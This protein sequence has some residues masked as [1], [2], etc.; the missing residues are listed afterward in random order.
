MALLPAIGLGVAIVVLRLLAP[1]IW[2]AVEEFA[3]S[4]FSTG[5]D[6]LQYLQAAVGAIPLPTL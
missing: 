1:Q 4:L 3:L 5:V 2:S 6:L